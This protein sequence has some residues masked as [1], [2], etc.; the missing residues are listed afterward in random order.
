M[1][2]LFTIFNSKYLFFRSNDELFTN[3][4][5]YILKRLV[6]IYRYIKDIQLKLIKG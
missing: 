3:K 1:E 6:E 4:Q 5:T 2:S